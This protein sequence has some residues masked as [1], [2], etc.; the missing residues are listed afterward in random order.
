MTRRN[1]GAGIT[2]A[3]WKENVM[4]LFVQALY[5]GFFWTI[6]KIV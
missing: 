2:S 1:L 6:L 3:T 5:I 4:I